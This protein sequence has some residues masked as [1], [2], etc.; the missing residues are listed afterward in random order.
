MN[1]KDERESIGDLSV[2]DRVYVKYSAVVIN[3][4]T[5]K[6][7]DISVEIVYHIGN[8]S[9]YLQEL[10]NSVNNSQYGKVYYE[11]D[12]EY[13]NDKCFIVT[14]TGIIQGFSK[15]DNSNDI[16]GILIDKKDIDDKDII[17]FAPIMEVKKYV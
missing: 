15:D 13:K 3:I 4:D 14:H 7:P 9:K 10:E 1:W 6:F 16:T 12:D 2:G 17:N 11:A 8:F 5:V